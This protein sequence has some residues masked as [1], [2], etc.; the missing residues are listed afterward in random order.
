[1]HVSD[2]TFNPSRLQ[3]IFLSLLSVLSIKV[4][5]KVNTKMFT[6]GC[7]PEVERKNHVM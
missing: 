3:P 6:I 2:T 4:Q 5:E 7:N 1:M